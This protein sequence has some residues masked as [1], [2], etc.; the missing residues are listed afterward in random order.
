MNDCVSVSDNIYPCR[1]PWLARTEGVA[2]WSSDKCIV[3]A[4]DTKYHPPSPYYLVSRVVSVYLLT[5][6][7]EHPAHGAVP[8]A[9]HDDH[10][11]HGAEEAEAGCGAALPEV[12]HLPRVQ[13]VQEL[14]VQPRP[15]DHDVY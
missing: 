1:F 11:L 14:A 9:H 7:L 10:I 12:V 15:L 4:I 6:C 5:E 8:A 3:G 2:Q 13:V